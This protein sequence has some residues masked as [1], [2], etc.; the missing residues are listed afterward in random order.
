MI[1]SAGNGRASK[2]LQAF[3]TSLLERFDARSPII[4][5]E[6]VAFFAVIGLLLA[7]LLKLIELP[8]D[9]RARIHL[10]IQMLVNNG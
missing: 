8:D 3:G 10:T 9:E 1:L 2:E 6:R 4:P 7:D 5:Y